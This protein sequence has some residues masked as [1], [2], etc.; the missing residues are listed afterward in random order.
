MTA[1]FAPSPEGSN[2]VLVTGPS[3]AGRTTALRV[4]EDEGFEVVDN[5]PLSLVS[6][7]LG[8]DLERPLA[9]GLDVRSRGFTVDSILHLADRLRA[10]PGVALRILY[11][12][13]A[14]ETLINRFSETRRRH[15]LAPDEDTA[16]GVERELD[17]LAPLVEHADFAID[18]THLTVHD[19]REEVR[20]RFAET[21]REL[22][23]S[24][25]SFSY[26]N[27]LPSGL[28]MVFDVRFLTNPHWVPKLR[29]LTGCDGAV[30]GYIAS[31]PRFGAFFGQVTDLI[32]SLLPAYRQEG[33]AHLSVGF[34]C[35]GGRHRSVAV[36]EFLADA[37]AENGWRVSKR[38]REMDFRRAAETA[39]QTE[40]APGDRL[41]RGSAA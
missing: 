40:P 31:D 14:A 1:I 20:A 2:L 8:K 15:P 23:I 13:C 17:L 22:A 41:R 34:G 6:D 7:L 29:P 38:H 18:T 16:S 27:G 9:L 3:G 32:L 4:L 11:L 28:D 24:V 19:L 30:Q 5:P 26:R 37:L 12:D 39:P 35:T 25:Q 21:G 36:A 10:D 33:R